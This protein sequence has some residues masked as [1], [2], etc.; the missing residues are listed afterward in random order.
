[1]TI[2]LVRLFS[3]FVRWYRHTVAAKTETQFDDEF[4]PLIDRSVR[5]VMFTLAALA[6]LDSFQIDIKGLVAVLGVGSLAVA[7]AAKDTLANI[8]GGFVIMIDR[9]FRVGDW[10]KLSDARPERVHKIGIRSTK[11]LTRDNTL[12]I[13]P[14]AELMNSTIH[15]ITYPQPEVRIV[16]N[17]G[18]GYDSDIDQVKEI[19]LQAAAAHPKVVDKPPP[20]F[21]FLNFGDSSLDVSVRCRVAEVRDFFIVE[22]EVREEILRR[23]RAASIEIPFPQRVVTMVPSENAQS[24]DPPEQA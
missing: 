18:V 1:V 15:N 13:V 3:A 7:L 20:R 11:F 4:L 12:I 5:I 2:L 24:S 23:F 17:V 16:V 6:I 19:M 14:N 21:R 10:V 9:P 22:G 8:I